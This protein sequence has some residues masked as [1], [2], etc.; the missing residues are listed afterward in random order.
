MQGKSIAV[1]ISFRDF[2][3]IEYFVPRAI[4]LAAGARVVTVS[5]Q[6]GRAIGADGGD[7]R[8]DMLL[9]DMEPAD[10]DAVVFIGGPGALKDL[11]NERSY[12]IARR[13]A[14]L[15]KVLGAICISP[16]ILA[17]AGVLEG[18]KAAVWSGPLQKEPVRILKGRGAV[19][20]EK[21]VVRDGKIVTGNGPGA[22]RA[23]AL[24]LIE[25]LTGD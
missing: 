5:S 6:K 10:F 1:M 8:V 11:D 15:G 17:K 23:F 20:E 4:F 13:T 16:V 7:I 22:A 2:R 21:P 9:E 12:E 19:Y 18:K 14:K 24:S 25:V 3:D